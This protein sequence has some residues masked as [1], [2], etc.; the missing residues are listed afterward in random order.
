MDID[1]REDQAD[2]DPSTPIL[3][4]PQSCIDPVLARFFNRSRFA[5]LAEG[6]RE[7][8]AK[9][10]R[11]FFTFL[12]NRGRNWHEADPDDLLDWEAWRRRD[13]SHG[14][15][16]SGSN[17]QRELAALRLLYEW[18]QARG[19]IDR[20]PV[21]VHTVRLRYGTAVAVADQT[22]RDVR[23]SNVKRL[24]PKTRQLWRD[25]GL[26]GYDADQKPTKRGGAATTPAT[27]A[28][29]T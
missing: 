23:S 27:L 20:S 12:W 8:Y 3:I 18:A 11:L 21:P 19:H 4:D 24:T 13:R 22:P 5:A 15:R 17:W 7:A 1:D 10:Y 28:S 6:T 2:I 29:P 9:D 16:I 14:A 25:V 26:L